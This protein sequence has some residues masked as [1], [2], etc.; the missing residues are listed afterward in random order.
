MLSIGWV[1]SKPLGTKTFASQY[2]PVYNKLLSN[3][4]TCTG[5][6]SIKRA[7]ATKAH[8][9][10]FSHSSLA[11]VSYSS[12]SALQGSLSCVQDAWNCASLANRAISARFPGVHRVAVWRHMSSI[13]CT[14]QLCGRCVT[15]R[16]QF[17]IGFL[18]RECG[19]R[20]GRGNYFAC[21][22]RETDFS[23]E[24]NFCFDRSAALFKEKKL[25]VKV[26]YAPPPRFKTTHWMQ[27][28]QCSFSWYEKRNATDIHSTVNLALLDEWDDLQWNS[29]ETLRIFLS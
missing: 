27:C 6:A 26:H 2:F 16:K 20:R 28:V 12:V 10:F 19:Y 13:K 22:T 29:Q 8:N 17:I 9:T 21:S 18:P 15:R 23:F 3:P 4:V 7:S 1:T 11:L 5:I 24:T 25:C 14:H